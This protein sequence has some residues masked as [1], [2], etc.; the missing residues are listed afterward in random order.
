[1]K[2]KKI[3]FKKIKVHELKKEKKL[4]SSKVDATILILLF[5]G[6]ALI[7][8]AIL[9]LFQNN[10]DWDLVN[11]FIFEWHTILFLL[12]SSVIFIFTLWLY[13]ILGNR[14]LTV[15]LTFLI[16]L[17][18]GVATWQKMINRSEPLYP[19]ELS[20][21]KELSFMVSMIESKVVLGFL[22]IILVVMAL[23]YV[24]T[25]LQTR[26]II[27][28]NRHKSYLIRFIL[29][30]TTSFLLVYI[31]NFNQPGNLL[32]KAYD[33]NA[34]WIPYSQQMNYYNNG[35]IGGFL[36]N[37]KVEAMAEPKGYSKEKIAE[38]TQKYKK[39][40]EEVNQNRSGPIKNTNIIY[41]MNESFSDPLALNG[42]EI[43]KDPIP[44]TRHLMENNRSGSILSQGYGGGTANIEFEALTGFSMEPM[45]PQLTT[46]YT[47]LLAKVTNFPSI[48]SYLNEQ[49]YQTTAIHPY[50][51]SM[52]KRQNVYQSLGF[53]N[54]INEYTM[55]N[56]E[57]MES[58]P[59]FS[60]KA[61]YQEVL[62]T[63][64]ASKGSNFIH[65]VTMQN[66]MPYGSKYVS[67]EFEVSGTEND[68]ITSNYLKDLSYSDQALDN[69][70]KQIDQLAEPTIVIFWGDHLP[71]VYGD[72]IFNQNS[73]DKMHETPL[74]IYSNVN[75]KD[76]ELGMIS[77][78]YFAPE[79]LEVA[80]ADITGFYALLNQLQS[81]LPAFEKEMYLEKNAEKMKK[82]VN[83]LSQETQALLADYYMIQYD[84]TTGKKYSLQTNLFAHNK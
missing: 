56:T 67:S 84:I 20:M 79:L 57:K 55:K 38:L 37:L 74:L 3:Y 16:S 64:E 13:V 40:A 81:N 70:I 36:F 9:Q 7:N 1:M 61:A 29:F 35:F 49:N 43:A 2:P 4:L 47:Q 34:Y 15:G 75:K 10:L 22:L 8:N 42:M 33:P 39:I 76:K 44:L 72:V 52:Y 71:S 78:I 53:Q 54:F 73:L 48:V 77:P 23:A 24:F 51:T 66:H 14:Y 62:D 80:N 17:G 26:F 59:Y 31:A 28:Y 65:L 19:S 32:K 63:L 11:K 12:G 25:R 68:Q 21:I 69:F 46:P 41:I 60:D 18:L 58:N 30:I 27:K 5:L 45:N 50:N 82:S 6:S 83:E